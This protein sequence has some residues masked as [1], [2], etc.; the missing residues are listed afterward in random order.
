[1]DFKDNDTKRSS[2][3]N[4]V[5]NSANKKSSQISINSNGSLTANE[6]MMRRPFGVAA[7]DLTPI[8]RK[9]EDFKNNLDL[10]FLLCEKD[11]LDN[12][13]KKL[14]FNK[15]IGK[16]D[17]K[18]AVSVEILHGDTKQ[19]KE[20]FPHLI[21]GSVPFAR[22]MGFPEVIFPGDV[23]NDLYVTLMSG[24]FSKG[25]KGS[26]KNIEVTITVCD[27]N[28]INI[29]GVISFGVGS[30]L[31]DEYKSVIYYH[32]DKPK[33]METFKIQVSIE[34]FKQC[35]LKF[36]FKH[37][38]SNEQKDKT[39]KPFGL[40]YVRLLQE[41]GTTLPQGLHKLAVYK[42]DHKKLEKILLYRIWNYHQKLM[43]YHQIRNHQQ[44]H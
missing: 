24:E 10:P 35:H 41:N 25:A 5:L 23:R 44:H 39:E 2:V 22:K 20:E 37:R 7:I 30:N 21:H 16:I 33:W 12:T 11:N 3:T 31:I 13:L 34:E 28:G 1:M 15:D 40:S 8:V 14:L 9:P 6:Q 4:S 38:S 32:E 36:L 19:I 29:P 17:S 42:I 27:E 26:D 18:L 43:K